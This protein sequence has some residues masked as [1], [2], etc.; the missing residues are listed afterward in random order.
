M[1]AEFVSGLT[2]WLL[3]YWVHATVLLAVA[4]LLTRL[5]AMSDGPRGPSTSR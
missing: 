4:A 3:T 5:R 1:R 2:D